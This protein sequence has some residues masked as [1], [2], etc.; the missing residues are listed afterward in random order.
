MA[1]FDPLAVAIDWLDAY[2]GVAW[3]Q[4][5]AMYSQ[6]AVIECG[7]GSHTRI[8]GREHIAAYLL[9]QMVEYPSLGLQD[10]WMEG[11]N[12]VLDFRTNMGII[13]AVLQIA[14][15]GTITRCSCGFKQ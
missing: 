4:I 7:C 6:Q 13:R 9:H 11:E 5:V 10:I 14:L 2:S 1:D 3:D 12:V 15:D 8:S